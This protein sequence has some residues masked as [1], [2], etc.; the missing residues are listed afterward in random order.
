M[1]PTSVNFLPKTHNPDISIRKTSD[2]FELRGV[3]Q[4]TWPV[5][6]KTVK[7]IKTKESLISRHSLDRG[8]KGDTMTK[9]N[10]VY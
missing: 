5:L 4:N 1:A 10:V 2:R 6:L 9:C 3:S 8:A 7:V